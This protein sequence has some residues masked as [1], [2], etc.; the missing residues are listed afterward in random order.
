VEQARHHRRGD[1]AGRLRRREQAERR[2]AQLNRGE[3]GDGGVLGGPAQA[4]PQP[5]STNAA[6][7]TP[8]AGPAAASST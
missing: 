5:A 3:G 7:S 6:S 2:P 4:V 8:I 1:V